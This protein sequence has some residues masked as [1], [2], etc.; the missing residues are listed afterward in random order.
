MCVCVC[1]VDGGARE[2]LDRGEEPGG[3]V[4]P[5]SLRSSGPH[6]HTHHDGHDQGD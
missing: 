2:H 5:G 4:S 6:G 3:A 1:V